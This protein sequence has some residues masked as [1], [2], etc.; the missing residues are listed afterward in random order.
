MGRTQILYQSHIPYA[1]RHAYAIRL[2]RVGD[3]GQVDEPFGQRPH[4]DLPRGHVGAGISGGLGASGEGWPV[5]S[6]DLVLVTQKFG[7][8]GWG[9]CD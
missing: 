7:R 6:L 9:V 1:L 5:A 3:R 8:Y 4:S 2:A